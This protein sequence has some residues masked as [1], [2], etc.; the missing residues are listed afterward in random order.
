MSYQIPYNTICDLVRTCVQYRTETRMNS[1]KIT[2]WEEKVIPTCCPGYAE[3]PD[4]SCSPI[5]IDGCRNGKCVGPNECK[6]DLVPNETKPGYM[7][8]TCSR[9]VCLNENKWGPNCQDDCTC[10]QNAFCH[11]Y[12]GKCICRSNW[13][14]PNCT[15]ACESNKDP[16]C[17][18]ATL[19]QISDPEAN[20][21][22]NDEILP[23]MSA[24]SLDLQQAPGANEKPSDTTNA[25]QYALTQTTMNIILLLIT[26]T[27]IFSL[28]RYRQR[29][30]RITNELY[31]SATGSS[32]SSRS[33]V[34]SS[35]D[36]GLY[37]VPGTIYSEPGS[38]NSI[39]AAMQKRPLVPL[40]Q[41][42][43]ENNNS[44]L[45]K[46]LSFASAT[47][48][49]IKGVTTTS[50]GDLL[51]QSPRANTKEVSLRGKFLLDPLV[52]SRLARSQDK[53]AENVYCVP[54]SPKSDFTTLNIDTNLNNKMQNSQLSIN[55]IADDHYQVPKSPNVNKPSVSSGTQT[56]NPIN[57]TRNQNLESQQL[58]NSH[59][60][61]NNIQNSLG[62]NH[63]Q[64]NDEDNND[65][66][67]DDGSN[68]YE[69]IPPRRPSEDKE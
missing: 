42:E 56:F 40:P 27:L 67:Q 25:I 37:A 19:L 17:D 7:G 23:R 44:Q 48:N 66:Y 43:A 4:Q 30:E 52:E 15:E 34:S 65:Y 45:S 62:Y 5:C 47:R 6:C 1:R 8:N 16:G 28:V 55:S 69:E 18:E 2:V 35:G 54:S 59:N 9:F 39:A 22:T 41:G 21:I 26:F 20:M 68:I 49:I 11:A 63:D 38:R 50:T 57:N 61:S 60:I 53:A 31:Y 29:L 10:S 64:I 24:L 51:Q 58:I 33:D 3:H 46:N 12:T 32:S 14:G 13:R 36:S